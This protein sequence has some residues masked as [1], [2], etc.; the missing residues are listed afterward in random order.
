MEPTGPA[1]PRVGLSGQEASRG[2]LEGGPGARLLG[3]MGWVMRCQVRGVGW[4]PGME[5][6][7][8][9]CPGGQ[10]GAQ[11]RWGRCTGEGGGV[12]P[13]CGVPGGALVRGD[14]AVPR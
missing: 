10:D 5:G 9:P 3:A 12:V 2:A 14:R 8:V 6:W 4:C 13:R 7:A 11:V 1:V